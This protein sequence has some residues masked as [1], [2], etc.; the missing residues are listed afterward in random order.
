[1]FDTK[2]PILDQLRAGE[3]GRAAFRQ[4][5]FGDGGVI[6]PI[7]QD[8]AGELVAFANAD[9]GAL[10]LGVDD[11]GTVRGIP[12]NR[13]GDTERWLVSVARNNCA[14]PI[15]PHVRKVRLPVAGGDEQ[16]ILVV[17]VARGASVHRTSEGRYYARVGP[18]RQRLTSTELARLFLHR[19]RGYVFDGEPVFTARLQDLDRNRLEAF[20]GRSPDIPW[21]DLLRNTRVVRR[22]EQ[23]TDRPSVAGLLTF[24]S[25]PTEHLRSAWIEAACYGGTRLSSD[26]LIHEER[27]HGPAPD[28]MD[29]AIAFV[30]RFGAT[31]DPARRPPYDIETVEEAIVNAVVHRDY[32][33]HGGKIRLFLFAD[34][35]EL[36]S[37]GKLP[38]TMTL[39]EMPYRVFTRNQL[40]VNFLSRS[41]SRRTGRVFL[42]SRG[43]GV[44]KILEGGEAHSGRR[45]DYELFGEEL[46]LTLWAKL[47]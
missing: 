26:D 19:E 4:M 35:L 17:R 34:R 27:L 44:R 2:E 38:G 15:R 29:A 21:P 18:K 12:A 14:P 37:P 30:M 3:D 8:L 11:S 9:G 28:Q 32:S 1:M 42:E 6:S 7:T 23:D 33:I 47:A 20:F 16:P 45:P 10:F 5:R 40:L 39:G 31:G 25:R 41:H 46:R 36:Y 13:V 24:G 43:E 22:D